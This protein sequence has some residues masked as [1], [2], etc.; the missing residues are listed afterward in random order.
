MLL[1]LT[2]IALIAFPSGLLASSI[3]VC[4]S[5]YI[6]PSHSIQVISVSTNTQQ[7]IANSFDQN[8]D[9]WG[10]PHH[11]PQTARPPMT[12]ISMPQQ[13]LW[14]WCFH[15]IVPGLIK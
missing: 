2:I 12:R 10:T 6:R 13:Q 11:C 4:T 7:V 5:Y 3:Q 9:H 1:V 8:A 15:E 14:C